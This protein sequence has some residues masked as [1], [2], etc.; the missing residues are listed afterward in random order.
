M[1]GKKFLLVLDDV[2]IE[3]STL[4]EPSRLVLKYGAQGSRILVTTRKNIVANIMESAC[5]I[6]LGVLSDKDCWLMYSKIA[7]SDKNPKQHEQ[8][9]DLGRQIAKKCQGLP[10]AAKTL[11]SLMRFKRSRE[12]WEMVLCSSLWELEDVERGLFTPLLLSYYDL[13]SPMKRCLSYCAVFPKDYVFVSDE[14]VFMWMAQGYIDSK[15]N[16][17]MEIIEKKYF[18]NLAIRSFFQNFEKVGSE[19]NIIRCKMHDIVHDTLQLIT[20]NEGMTINNYKDLGSDYKYAYHLRFE[21]SRKPQFLRSIY[22][23]QNLRTLIL[24]KGFEL[25]Q[26]VPTC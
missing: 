16:M 22:S 21:I 10:L 2:W 5:M 20:K 26:F 13:S 12:Q 1:G 3:D 15:E 18:E 25:I 4:W 9:Q 24:G 8:L 7:F 17:E 19:N 14:L 6:T 23:A 11:G